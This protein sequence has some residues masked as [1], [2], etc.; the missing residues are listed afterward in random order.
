MAASGTN[1]CASRPTT[2]LRSRRG[3]A[4]VLARFALL[5]LPAAP[6]FMPRL[7][8]ALGLSGNL[9]ADF[10]W[11]D[12]RRRASVSRSALAGGTHCL[13]RFGTRSGAHVNGFLDGIAR[14]YAS[15]MD[16]ADS[17]QRLGR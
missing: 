12:A 17:N 7:V 1:G 4:R 6:D 2:L 5:A 14:S 9:S 3:R 8:C 11:T 10:R 15:E 13:D 16:D